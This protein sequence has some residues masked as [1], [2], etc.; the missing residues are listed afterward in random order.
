M[1]RGN[2]D[3]FKTKY[4]NDSFRW[5]KAYSELVIINAFTRNSSECF[6]FAYVGQIPIFKYN[7]NRN[8]MVEISFIH[9]IKNEIDNK[10]I[11]ESCLAPFHSRT[12]KDIAKQLMPNESDLL[13]EKVSNCEREQFIEKFGHA[14]TRSIGYY[15]KANS[16]EITAYRVAAPK[17][18]YGVK[19]LHKDDVI[20]MYKPENSDIIPFSQSKLDEVVR[21]KLF[22]KKDNLKEINDLVEIKNGDIVIVEYIDNKCSINMY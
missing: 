2:K 11:E 3:E 12:N 17:V 9:N 1:K 5:Y 13:I 21:K 22:N 15:H 19:A 8:K 6:E 14:A 16:N 4:K 10:T 20:V 18:S 7:K